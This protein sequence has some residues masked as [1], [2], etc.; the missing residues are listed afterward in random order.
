MRGPPPRTPM[1]LHL[2]VAL[3]VGD[4][5]V[6]RLILTLRRVRTITGHDL[7][8]PRPASRTRRNAGTLLQRR[9]PT[10]NTQASPPY[11]GG[12]APGGPFRP[13]PQPRSRL[14]PAAVGSS[15]P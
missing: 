1:G 14:S 2:S 12:T 9:V 4:G 11:G 13:S 5:R 6:L 10:R 7:I 15:Q 8:W 3:H